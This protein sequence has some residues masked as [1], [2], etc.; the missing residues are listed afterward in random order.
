MNI[1]TQGTDNGGITLSERTKRELLDT[2]G[3]SRTDKTRTTDKTIPSFQ[4]HK[5]SVKYSIFETMVGANERRFVPF[6]DMPHCN[7]KYTR[8]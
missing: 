3:T 8:E 2:A 6:E 7:S 5:A 4:M 1:R